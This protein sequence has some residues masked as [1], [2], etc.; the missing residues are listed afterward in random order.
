M[1]APTTIA[2][3]C[4]HMYSIKGYLRSCDAQLIRIL[5]ENQEKQGVCGN[6]CEIGVHHGRLFLLLALTRKNRESAIAIDLFEDDA[7][8][9]NSAQAGR[10]GAL[11]RNAKRLNIPLAD[12]EI[13]KG[14]SL[15]LTGEAIQ[16]LA[17]GPIRFF[18]VDGGHMYRHVENDLRLAQQSL[19]PEGIIAL[20]DFF[21][22]RWPEVSAATIDFM[23]NQQ[24][25]VPVFITPSKLYFARREFTKK[26]IDSVLPVLPTK[27]RIGEPPVSFFG[28]ETF[29]IEPTYS[30]RL[31]EKI[32]G[33]LKL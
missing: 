11:Q 19:I 8:N 32:R 7:I 15:D 14:S 23:R 16:Q 21:C 5:L 22:R 27:L 20:D 26:L 24:E 29:E 18:S 12:T 25:F 9:Q 3:I 17:G 28:H 4:K 33:L 31:S 10:N 30:T 2:Y 13:W 1:R 6:L